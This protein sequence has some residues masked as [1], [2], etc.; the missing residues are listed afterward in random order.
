[1]QSLGGGGSSSVRGSASSRAEELRRFSAGEAQLRSLAAHPELHADED[2]LFELLSFA[3]SCVVQLETAPPSES[4][5]LD[6]AQQLLQAGLGLCSA[7][8]RL[9]VSGGLVKGSDGLRGAGASELVFTTVAAACSSESGLG[10]SLLLGFQQLGGLPLLGKAACHVEEVVL[11]S[12]VRRLRVVASRCGTQAR[13]QGNPEAVEAVGRSIES[14]RAKLFE[15]LQSLACKPARQLRVAQFKELVAEIGGVLSGAYAGSQVFEMGCLLSMQ[16]TL[17]LTA[18]CPGVQETDALEAVEWLASVLRNLLD[19]GSSGA[20]FSPVAI[21]EWVEDSGLWKTLLTRAACRTQHHAHHLMTVMLT[22]RALAPCDLVAALASAGALSQS[23]VP[24]PNRL[25]MQGALL[26]AVPSLEAD[27]VLDLFGELCGALGFEHLTEEGIELMVR[28]TQRALAS[29]YDPVG[30]AGAD[31]TTGLARS[32]AVSHLLRFLQWGHRQEDGGMQL[33][34]TLDFA[35]RSLLHVLLPHPAL[36]PLLPAVAAE[37]LS[38]AAAPSSGSTSAA[39]GRCCRKLASLAVDVAS[40]GAAGD[41]AGHG[42]DSITHSSSVTSAVFL[43]CGSLP[44]IGAE[45]PFDAEHA[46][47]WVAALIDSLA[48]YLR[49]RGAQIGTREVGILWGRMIV[50]PVLGL[51]VA[52]A[53]MQYFKLAF[54]AQPSAGSSL[55]APL[56][57]AANPP[58]EVRLAHMSIFCPASFDDDPPP[59]SAAFFFPEAAAVCEAAQTSVLEASAP[60]GFGFCSPPRLPHALRRSLSSE[61]LADSDL[62]PN[63]PAD[64]AE[65]AVAARAAGLT[66][67]ETSSAAPRLRLDR[68]H[69]VMQGR[70]GGSTLLGELTVYDATERRLWDEFD[71]LGRVEDPEALKQRDAAAARCLAELNRE[72]DAAGRGG[73]RELPSPLTEARRKFSVLCELIAQQAAAKAGVEL[74]A[75]EEA[76]SSAEEDLL[77]ATSAHRREVARCRRRGERG[78]APDTVS[79]A[80]S[81]L[82]LAHL[83]LIQE[84]RLAAQRAQLGL[85]EITGAQGLARALRAV[86]C[87][88]GDP[89]LERMQLH[90]RWCARQAKD[91]KVNSS[92]LA[93]SPNSDPGY[94]APVGLQDHLA[95]ERSLEEFPER[96]GSL[97]GA[98]ADIRAV[99]RRGRV[100]AAVRRA[101]IGAQ[102]VGTGTGASSGQSTSSRPVALKVYS[103][104]AEE[105][106]RRELRALMELQGSGG[107]ILAVLDVFKSNGSIYLEFPWCAGGSLLAW[108]QKNGPSIVGGSDAE[109]FVRC[110]S[111][112]RGAWQ[113]IER[114]HSAGAAHGDFT[115]ENV[116]LT[117]EHRPLLAD[118]SRLPPPTP[119]YAAPEL[120]LDSNS[121]ATQAADLYAGGAAMAK[122]FM[123]LE[124]QVASCPYHPTRG[125]RCLPLEDRT[126]VDL[127]DLLQQLLA[128]RQLSSCLRIELWKLS[129]SCGGGGCS[130]LAAEGSR[131]PGQALVEAAELLREEYRG[132]RVDEPLMFS[133]SAVFDAIAQ[134]KIGDWPEDALLGEWRVMLNDESGV[135]GGGLRREV[136]SLFFEQLESSCLVLK[137]GGDGQATLFAADRR[138]AGLSPQ[139]WRQMWSSVGAMI[140]RALVHF[141]NAPTA[142]S[143]A[144]FDCALGR[145]DRLPPDD[146]KGAD[147]EDVQGSIERL[148]KL[149]EARGDD[150]ARSALLDLLRRLRHADPHK[151]AGY[152]WMLAQRADSDR[153]GEDPGGLAASCSDLTADSLETMGAMLEPQSFLFLES[154]SSRSVATAAGRVRLT[155]AGL[156]WVM[157]WDIYLKY[158]GGGDRWVAYESLAAGFSARGKR[159]ELWTSLTG[160]QI[161]ETLEGVVLTPGIV[162]ANLEFKP[163]YGYD[164]QIQIFRDAINSFSADELSRFLRFATGIGRLPASQRFP[165]G[166]KLTIRFMP[167]DDLDRL[168]SA[169]TCFWVMDVPPYEDGGALAEK[170]RLAIAAPQ[171]FAL[172]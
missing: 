144:I 45:A 111:I 97:E 120:E 64:E 118:F 25:A 59:L 104:D 66:L 14:F 103:A 154:L 119:D 94:T 106:C 32:L 54:V 31:S 17:A 91:D 155:G 24:P 9:A 7:W 148:L 69:A 19:Q 36:S 40:M 61:G 132:R 62:A 137:A 41:S 157:L 50:R 6:E 84:L 139:Q 35:R 169:H 114:V 47:S 39:A 77:A 133:R 123:G 80:R 26:T 44:K 159:Q 98:Y 164:T 115:L 49:L 147:E 166:Q 122:A 143:S 27:A 142:F 51:S 150:W 86:G 161:V 158:L 162:I 110:L 34:E 135:D 107:Q 124:L 82:S 23:E 85:V 117:A 90:S 5:A 163:S 18:H 116:L 3:S 71:E 136:V 79:S 30:A 170:L 10:A 99:S 21:R 57:A 101:R 16:L 1:R 105:A 48:C 53:A 109:S 141:G 121:Q 145:L 81:A 112:F 165:A 134:S 126:D 60:L 75:A 12:V 138:K 65:L 171:P 151:E 15:R 96:S 131:S 146:V 113:A 4:R 93:S 83:K 72:L 128:G 42:S 2:Q 167:G 70:T 55:M 29:G 100:F 78:P 22:R 127:A 125:Q 156:E 140:L 38:L 102:V 76:F 74:S 129:A 43:L 11:V 67:A 37:A 88:H 52:A 13:R 20:L 152:R 95:Q 108:C 92:S 168:P 58:P 68:V 56:L 87:G 149:R 153:P 172:S 46:H 8:L 63:L 89:L 160:E 28:L 33:Q 130:L 73:G